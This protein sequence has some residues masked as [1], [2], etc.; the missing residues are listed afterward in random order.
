[1]EIINDTEILA[2]LAQKEFSRKYGQLGSNYEAIKRLLETYIKLMRQTVEDYKEADRQ[3][4]R[5]IKTN[6]VQIDVN[7]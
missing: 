1:M 2:G 7:S 3:T 6:S 4:S 5:Y